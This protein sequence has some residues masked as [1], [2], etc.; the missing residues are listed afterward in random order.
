[1]PNSLCPAC[2]AYHAV[3]YDQLGLPVECPGCRLQYP[4]NRFVQTPR[5]LRPDSTAGLTL[6]LSLLTLSL[7]AAAPAAFVAV[8]SS[9]DGSSTANT[10]LGGALAVAIAGGVFVARW[11]GSRPPRDH[12]RVKL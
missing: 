1:M 6:G 3:R 4:A 7:M 9:G 11:L 8:R 2:R 12:S 5:W 10:V